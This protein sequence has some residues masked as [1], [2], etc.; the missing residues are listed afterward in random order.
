[1]SGESVARASRVGRLAGAVRR[2]AL[3]AAALSG[4]VPGLGQL[5]AGSARRALIVALP[6][7]LAIGALAAVVATSDRL[8]LLEALLSP[9]A[10]TA[11]LGANALLLAYRVLA[12]VDAYRLARRRWGGPGPIL[13]G[14]SIVGLAALL[15]V[16]GIE[17]AVPAA[18]AQEAYVAVTTVFAPDEPPPPGEAVLPDD[19]FG[20]VPSDAPLVESP[21]PLE[22]PTGTPTVGPPIPVIPSADPLLTP[23]PTP[24]KAPGKVPAWASDGRLDLLLI[25]TDAG[26]DRWKLRT[27]TMILLSVD[28]R[29][30]RAALFGF[31]RNLRNVPLPRETAGAFACRC[32]PGLLNALWVYADSHPTGFPGGDRRGFRAVAGAVHQLSG[33][34]ID[35][36]AVVNMDGFVDLIDLLGGL[37]IRVPEAVHDRMYPKP[38]GSGLMELNIAAGL[39]TMDGFTALAYARSRHQ[40]S[41]Y[42]RMRRQQDVLLALGAQAK[43][44]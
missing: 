39:Q 18:L 33:A 38:D 19:D 42:G 3:V 41:D 32:W 40:D 31:P 5:W 12:M 8:T 34:R 17:H 28:V 30:G 10:L 9:D 6:V 24:T 37:R 23:A 35:G 29:S 43:P 13:R 22:T 2:S 25:G 36:L 1:M 7:V 14:A 4:L 27:D 11:F 44:C 26:P 21:S 15:A 16:T 20:E